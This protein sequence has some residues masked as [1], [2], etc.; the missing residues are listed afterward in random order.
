MNQ[1][2]ENAFK[3]FF[4]SNYQRAMSQALSLVKNEEVA[5]DIVQDSFEQLYHSCRDMSDEEM[6]NYLY[7]IVRNKCA[8]YFRKLSVHD[9]YSEYV[10]HFASKSET[11]DEHDSRIDEVLRLIA[12]LNPKT[13][14]ILT[15]HYLSGMKYSDI[16]AEMEISESAVKKHIMKGLKF[17][18]ENMIKNLILWYLFWQ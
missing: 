9:R 13:R 4:L 5:R 16:A 10:K 3:K 18:R 6:R 1:M 8:D 15:T 17:I 14:K 12:K 7:M 2:G 11:A